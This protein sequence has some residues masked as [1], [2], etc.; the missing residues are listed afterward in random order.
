MLNPPQ[1]DDGK[2]YTVVITVC[3]VLG[4]VAVVGIIVGVTTRQK[5]KR[6]KKALYY[7]EK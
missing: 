3:A 7:V 5:K 2:D 1:E 6:A 4:A